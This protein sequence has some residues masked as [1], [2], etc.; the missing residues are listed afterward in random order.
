MGFGSINLRN[1]LRKADRFVACGKLFGYEVQSLAIMVDRFVACSY[2]VQSLTI[3]LYCRR[4]YRL[5]ALT[6]L[7]YWPRKI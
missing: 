2:E 6:V 5:A 7:S 3:M 1:W 4:S